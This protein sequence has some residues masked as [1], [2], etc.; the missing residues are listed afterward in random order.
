M[1]KIIVSATQQILHGILHAGIII[2]AITESGYSSKALARALNYSVTEWERS[3]DKRRY[4]NSFHYLRRQKLIRYQYRGKQLHV[5]ITPKGERIV[6]RHNFNKLKIKK[7]RKWDGKWR[8][9]IFDIDSKQKQKR[10]ALRGKLKELGFFQLQ[11]SV[12]VCAYRCDR[13]IKEIRDFF[14][15]KQSELNLITATKVEDDYQMR[16][17]FKL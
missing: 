16:D 7:P 9:L 11:K 13:E 2:M 10:E 3:R 1:K 12:W 5:S 15:L 8:V 4:I 17:F 6:K 14:L